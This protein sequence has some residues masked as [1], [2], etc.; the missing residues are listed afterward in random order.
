MFFEVHAFQNALVST[1]TKY[2][3]KTPL[4]GLPCTVECYTDSQGSLYNP[5]ILDGT[6]QALQVA[7]DENSPQELCLVLP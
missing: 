4:H 2:Q 6:W 1:N 5:S 7:S 3:L